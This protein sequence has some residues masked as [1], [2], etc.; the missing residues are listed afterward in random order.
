MYG[1]KVE[2]ADGCPQVNPNEKRIA[3]FMK[4]SVPRAHLSGQ[5]EV[6]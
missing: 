5:A 6:I 1:V 2:G 4:V 3:D